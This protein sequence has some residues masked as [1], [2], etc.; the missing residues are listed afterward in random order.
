MSKT[1]KGTSD[2]E[3]SLLSAFDVLSYITAEVSVR[4]AALETGSMAAAELKAIA[5]EITTDSIF[6]ELPMIRKPPLP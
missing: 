5:H 2:K 4:T 6:L 3:A 1:L